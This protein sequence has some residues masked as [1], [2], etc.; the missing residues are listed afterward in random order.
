MGQIIRGFTVFVLG[1]VVYFKTF[2][3]LGVVN[4]KLGNQSYKVN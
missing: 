4:D 2:V 3:Q 1:G